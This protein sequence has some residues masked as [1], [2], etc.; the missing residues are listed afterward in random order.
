MYKGK[1]IA[2]VVPAYNEERFIAQTIKSVPSFVDR[3]YAVNDASTD[4][5]YK[6]AC[7]IASQNGRV[8]VINRE[9]RGGVGAA[10]VSGHKEALADE[11]DV[12]AVMAGDGEMDPAMLDKVLDP[13][14]EGRADYVKGNRFSVPE[15]KR[16]M[17]TWRVFGSFLLTYLTK[18]ASGYWHI[19][20]P[21]HGYTAM[22]RETFQKIALDKIY[23]GFAFENDMLVKLN[24]IG[25]RV[26][27]ISMPMPASARDSKK[28]S[29][30]RYPHFIVTTSWLLLKD[31]F[32]R[33]W[34]KY[35]KRA[36]S[37][38]WGRAKN[39]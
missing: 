31:F 32:W 12:V 2:V 16:E 13:V 38:N 30:I 15:H 9:S 27:E 14:V 36:L 39:A 26:V 28:Y 1:K 37:K 8:S 20:D 22:S 3:I 11:M 21:Q 6:I 17:S 7:S 34:V 19:S 24:V 29:K 5:T 10:I 18:V 33:L 35:V 23:K 25:A 4:D